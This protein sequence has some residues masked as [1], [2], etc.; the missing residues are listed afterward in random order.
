MWRSRRSDLPP[1]RRRIRAAISSVQP[2][3]SRLPTPRIPSRP[4]SGTQ[5]AHGTEPPGGAAD[6]DEATRAL[7]ELATKLGRLEIIAPGATGIEVDQKP[8]RSS[9]VFV[10]PG[11]HLV[12]ATV[13]GERVRREVTIDGGTAKTVLLE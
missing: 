9:S 6:R 13:D 10:N 8:A 7:V 1:A 3:R 5:P 11:S 12:E 4:R 2:S